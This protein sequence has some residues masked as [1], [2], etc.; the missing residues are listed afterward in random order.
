M[1]T[2]PLALA[3]TTRERPDPRNRQIAVYIGDLALTAEIRVSGRYRPAVTQADPLECYPEE[4][5]EVEIVRL[6]LSGPWRD[7]SD[8]LADERIEGDVQDQCEQY[9]SENDHQYADPDADREAWLE[10][11]RIDRQTETR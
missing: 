2:H 5:P 9:I 4:F 11:Q 7:V 8:L 3:A 10:R 6:W 1:N